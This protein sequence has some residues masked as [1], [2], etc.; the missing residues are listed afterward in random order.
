MRDYITQA[1]ANR[2]DAAIKAVSD[3]LGVDFDLLRE[4]KNTR[5]KAKNLNE[6]IR[7]DTR[8]K[9]LDKKKGKAFFED[10]KNA[11]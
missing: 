10:Q 7:F 4:I 8:I 2:E 5:L 6:F 3:A 9:T 1:Q 11:N